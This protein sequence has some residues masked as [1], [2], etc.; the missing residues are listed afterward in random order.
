MGR[1][2]GNKVSHKLILLGSGA[3]EKCCKAARGKFHRGFGLVHHKNG[4]SHKRECQQHCSLVQGTTGG[5]PLCLQQGRGW[6]D[7]A[8][9][10]CGH[11]LVP[12]PC[13]S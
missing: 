9:S 8:L 7:V 13:P 3:I 1:F 11:L 5:T 6:H 12:G 4:Q 2:S 10:Q